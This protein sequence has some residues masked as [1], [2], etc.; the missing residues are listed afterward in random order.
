M[1]S[2]GLHLWRV[3]RFVIFLWKSNELLIDFLDSMLKNCS[4][5]LTSLLQIKS[6]SVKLNERNCPE[7]ESSCKDGHLLRHLTQAMKCTN[8]IQQ[9]LGIFH[10]LASVNMIEIIH[11]D[12]S[13][14]AAP[15][16]PPTE[17]HERK[18]PTAGCRS[19]SARRA[20][21]GW[22]ARY[23][24]I[25]WPSLQQHPWREAP[26]WGGGP[27][28]SCDP[29]STCICSAGSRRKCARGKKIWDE[30][31]NVYLAAREHFS[32]PWKLFSNKYSKYIN[33]LY[34]RKHVV[35][36]V[37]VYYHNLIMVSF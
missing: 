4:F 5:F 6:K 29:H 12:S 7:A 20:Q 34:C 16:P 25:T 1:K 11:S 26:L 28:P 23:E 32:T 9:S 19:T 14:C 33:T 35:L 37:D 15:P 17:G 36:H 31:S 24:T 10:I 22:G 18:T 3:I 27:N 30:A 21:K 13:H 2:V 8:Q